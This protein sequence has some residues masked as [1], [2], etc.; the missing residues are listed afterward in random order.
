ML[1]MDPGMPRLMIPDISE[2]VFCMSTWIC[3]VGSAGLGLAPCI[4]LCLSTCDP[5][6]DSS[7]TLELIHVAQPCKVEYVLML[8]RFSYQT[9]LWRGREW[10]LCL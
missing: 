7:E 4:L 1:E 9:A 6:E 10:H 3:P 5:E 8:Y 2:L